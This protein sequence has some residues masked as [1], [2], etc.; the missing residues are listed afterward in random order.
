L[1]FNLGCANS[2]RPFQ[3]WSSFLLGIGDY[4][5]FMSYS[6][7]NVFHSGFGWPAMDLQSI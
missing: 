7:L 6:C 3:S 5:R 2:T 4:A 1:L